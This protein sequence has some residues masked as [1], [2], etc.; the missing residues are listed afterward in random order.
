VRGRALAL[1]VALLALAAALLAGCGG[2]RAADGDELRLGYFA[3]VTH[4]VPIVAMER[5]IYDRELEGTKVSPQLFISGPEAVSSI[6]AG[7]IDAAYVGPG[8]LVTALSRAPGEILVAAGANEGGATLIAAR[9]SGIRSVADLRGRRVAIPAHGNTQDLQLH[10]LLRRAGLKPADQGGDVTLVVVRNPLLASAITT[11][12]VDAAM[13]PEPWGSV[14]VADGAAR[15][16]LDSDQVLDGRSPT[17]ILV[18]SRALAER[19]P[20]LVR[21]L[22]R[23]NAEAVA[24]VRRDPALAGAAFNRRLDEVSGTT[25]APAVIRAAVDRQTA[26]TRVDPAQMQI[27]IDAA[28]DAGY[29]ARDVALDEVLPIR[30]SAQ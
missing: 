10:E 8:P 21:A 1:A 22:Q 12:V 25:L 19:R 13:A 18:V 2:E 14:L 3:N 6:L 15:V 26:T 5:G 7:S 4:A 23:A 28:G 20:D 16:V 24:L 11:G 27:M 30:P 9:G 17:T 29:Q